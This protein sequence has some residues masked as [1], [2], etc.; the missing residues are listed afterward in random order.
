[1]S[2]KTPVVFSEFFKRNDFS[3]SMYLYA[4]PIQQMFIY[5]NPTITPV[6]LMFLTAMALI[7]CCWFS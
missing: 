4:F 1:M 3:Y 5:K 6:A 2:F 7:P